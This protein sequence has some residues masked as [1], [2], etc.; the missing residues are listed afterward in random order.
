MGPYAR[1]PYSNALPII[2]PCLSFQ[3]YNGHHHTMKGWMLGGQETLS[4]WVPIP[5]LPTVV[6]QIAIFYPHNYPIAFYL[7]TELGEPAHMLVAGSQWPLI[8][9]FKFIYL[10]LSTH[11][12]LGLPFRV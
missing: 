2:Q 4:H 12:L 1:I 10:P 7:H 6:S 8:L 5:P 3:T 11:L 9:I